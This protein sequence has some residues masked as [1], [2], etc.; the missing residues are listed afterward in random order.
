MTKQ[1]MFRIRRRSVLA[2]GAGAAA[3]GWLALTGRDPSPPPDDGW[4]SGT[5][6]HILPTVDHQRFLIK[7]SFHQPPAGTV[8]LRV[9]DRQI[10]GINTDSDALFYRFDVAD[11]SP[12]TEYRLQLQSADADLC[13]PWPLKTFPHPDA[14]VDHFRLLAY[15]CAGGPDHL[16]NFG[17]FNAYLPTPIRQRLFARALRFKPHAVVANGDHVYWDLKSSRFM[18]NSWRAKQVAGLFDREQPILGTEN[19]QVLKRAIGPQL[20]GLYG[21]RFRSTPMFFLQDDHDYGENDEADE[22]LRTFPVDPFM[23]DLARTTQQLYYPELLIDADLPR[24]YASPSAAHCAENYGRL[25]FGRRFEGLLYDCRRHLRNAL[26]PSTPGGDS[27]FLPPAVENWVTTRIAQS[28]AAWVAQMPSTPVL[29]TAGKWAEWYPDVMNAEGELATATA[30][31]WWSQGWQDQHDRLLNA[32]VQRQDRSALVISG[33]LHATGTG[34]ILANRGTSYRHNP[35]TSILTGAI[36]TGALGWPSK[37][38]G[39]APRPARDIEAEILVEPLEENGFTLL[40]FGPVTLRVEHFKWT[41]AQPEPAIDTLQ[42]FAR[43][44]LPQHPTQVT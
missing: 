40:D 17:F 5:V 14:A 43:L 11:L 1:G 24:D 18:G 6:A 29:W 37:F 9:N 20:A 30:K 12:D 32:S 7:V 39:T 35:V 33:D 44:S 36:G 10:P 22:N 15:T 28:D 8:S 41:P 19:E 16:Y 25:R 26:D 21:V 23:V 38:R 2:L 4:N 34:Q 27:W 13:D 31:P 42:P 3:A